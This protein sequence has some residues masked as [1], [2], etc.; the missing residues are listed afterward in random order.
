[1]TFTDLLN[2]VLTFVLN[3]IGSILT[4]VLTPIDMLINQFVPQA[5][6]VIFAFFGWA[7]TM[8]L[9]TVSFFQYMLYVIGISPV[10]WH[11]IVICTTTLFSIFMLLFPLKMILN[12]FRGMR[13]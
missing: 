7:N 2:G 5:H 9:G 8:I 4:F 12:V 10:T 13:S 11:L 6:D 3:F 1:M